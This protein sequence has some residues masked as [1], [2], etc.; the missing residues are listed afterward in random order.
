MFKSTSLDSNSIC[1][2]INPKRFNYM[3]ENFK[4]VGLIPPKLFQGVRWNRGSNTGCVLAHI[5]ILNMC[6]MKNVPYVVIFEDDAYPRPDVKDK[7]N[8]ILS[9]MPENCGLLKLGNS[10][11]R[12]KYES[13]NKCMYYMSS[14]TAFGSHAYIVRKELYNTLIQ[15][16]IDLNVP[17]VAMNTE[18]YRDQFYKPYV[19]NLEYHLFIQKNINIDNIISQ[20][21][22]QRYWYPNSVDK[23]GMT[24]G[25]PCK[26]FV[27]RLIDD[28]F[29]YVEDI[30][31]IYNKNW[32][33][34][35]KTA[36][37]T[38][39][40]VYTKDEDGSL[41]K[42]S[43]NKWKIQWNNGDIGYLVYLKNVDGIKFFNIE[44]C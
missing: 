33:K 44:N 35:K 42:I 8:E 30:S 25:K 15:K 32:T 5:T 26:Y 31:I 41:E 14:G 23:T 38:D 20:K 22:G 36:I 4:S 7:W 17:D 21:G 18:Y 34:G 11:Y 2:S 3:C 27:D 1:M 28:E 40:I 10:S 29:K 39:K 24:S 13:V 12:G 19:L 9:N 6:R 37:V 16:M 43:D